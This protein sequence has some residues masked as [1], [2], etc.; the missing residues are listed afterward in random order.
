[1]SESGHE[2]HPSQL[3]ARPLVGQPRNTNPR[4][5]FRVTA[6]NSAGNEGARE[7]IICDQSRG[8]MTG[9]KWD[10]LNSD[11]RCVYAGLSTTTHARSLT[12]LTRETAHQAHFQHTKPNPVHG[13]CVHMPPRDHPPSKAENTLA[14]SYHTPVYTPPSSKNEPIQAI[15]PV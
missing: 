13:V 6:P 4:G 12:P 8:K 5:I 2:T 10:T 15:P 9:G 11:L 7:S 3:T 14:I 1:M